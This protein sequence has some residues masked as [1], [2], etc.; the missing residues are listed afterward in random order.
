VR[1]GADERHLFVILPGFSDPPF[2]VADLLMRDDPPL[3]SIAPV[4]PPEVTHVWAMSTWDT[5]SGM[6]WAAKSGWQYFDKQTTPEPKG[7]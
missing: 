5:K 4:L 7:Q 2:A 1:S 6:R 3:P